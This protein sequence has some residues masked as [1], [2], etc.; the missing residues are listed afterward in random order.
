MTGVSHKKVT[1]KPKKNDN[2]FIH[3]ILENGTVSYII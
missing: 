2:S 3:S 1:T